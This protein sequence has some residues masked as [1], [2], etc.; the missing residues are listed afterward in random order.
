M[1]LCVKWEAG[2]GKIIASNNS[3]LGWGGHCGVTCCQ[4]VSKYDLR[5]LFGSHSGPFQDLSDD[6]WAQVM[7]RNGG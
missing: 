4:N 2:G 7:H 3:D 6:S 1:F 5:D